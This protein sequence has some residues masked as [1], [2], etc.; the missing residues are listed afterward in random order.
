[1]LYCNDDAVD[2]AANYRGDL[3][4]IKARSVEHSIWFPDLAGPRLDLPA[5]DNLALY[6]VISR[7]NHRL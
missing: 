7:R 1:M 5:L 6:V 2:R 4:D 3:V